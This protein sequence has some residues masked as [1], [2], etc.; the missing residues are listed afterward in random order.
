MRSSLIARRTRA[1]YTFTVATALLAALLPDWL[2]EINVIGRSYCADNATNN[3][4]DYGAC[5]DTTAGRGRAKRANACTNTHA[6]DR[7]ILRRRT[8]ACKSKRKQRRS[9]HCCNSHRQSSMPTRFHA[10]ARNFLP[11]VERAEDRTRS[12]ERSWNSKDG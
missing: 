1:V 8:A 4:A 5:S 2:A 6:A 3:A 9:R 7:T 12:A 10:P 11:L